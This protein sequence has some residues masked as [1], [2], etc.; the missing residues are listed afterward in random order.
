VAAISVSQPTNQQSTDKQSCCVEPQDYP[1]H[2]MITEARKNEVLE[3][4]ITFLHMYVFIYLWFILRRS[5]YVYVGYEVLTAVSMKTS[6]PAKLL[7]R[8]R[9]T[10]CFHLQGRRVSFVGNQHEAYTKEICLDSISTL[11]ITII[12]PLKRWLIFTGLHSVISQNIDHL[13]LLLA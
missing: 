13:T 8:L 11:K 4:F 10:C 1:G 12:F 3:C 7:R 5:Y 9:A 6:S 2:F